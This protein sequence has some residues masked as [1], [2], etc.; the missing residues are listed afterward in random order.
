VSESACFERGQDIGVVNDLTKGD[1]TVRAADVVD[2]M[3]LP[4]DRRS[5]ARVTT[6][7]RFLGRVPGTVRSDK[8]SPVRVWVMREAEPQA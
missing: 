4:F 2:A 6:A 8:G 7:L 5:V 1:K 3:G